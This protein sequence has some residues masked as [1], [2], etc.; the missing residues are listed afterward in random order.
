M[1]ST[2][3]I[4]CKLGNLSLVKFQFA[5]IMINVLEILSVFEKVVGAPQFLWVPAKNTESWA[6]PK[7]TESES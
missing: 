4:M 5:W 2:Y 7:L 6:L 1:N 3:I